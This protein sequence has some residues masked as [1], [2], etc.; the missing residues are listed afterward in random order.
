MDNI[1]KYFSNLIQNAGD[2][3]FTVGKTQS[4]LSWNIGSEELL[5]FRS[6]EIIGKSVD[7]F[8]PYENKRQMRAMV[9][10]VFE[11]GTL[12]NLECELTNK[13]GRIVTAYLTASPVL[14]ENENVIAVSIIAKDITDQNKMLLQLIEKE[15]RASHLEALVQSLTTISHYIRNAVAIVSAKAE[16][17]KQINDENTYHELVQVCLKESKRIVAVIETLNDMVR[18]VEHKDETIETAEMAGAP[19]RVIDIEARLQERL[20]KMNDDNT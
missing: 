1:Q 19:S 5:G 15:K 11:E 9:V 4:I 8:S 12:K 3:I 6:D 7:T 18:E 10:E 17:S 16:V 2:A 14:D 13:D 20:K